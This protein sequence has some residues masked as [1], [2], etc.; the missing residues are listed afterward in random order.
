MLW[1]NGVFIVIISWEEKVMV[2]R[3]FYV[4]LAIVFGFLPKCYGVPFWYW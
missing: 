1:A 3:K 4:V 2:N